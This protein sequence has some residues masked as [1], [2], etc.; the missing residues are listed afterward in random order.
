MLSVIIPAFNEENL[1]PLLLESLRTQTFQ[2][3]EVIVSDAD[4]KDKTKEIAKLWGCKIIKG[5]SPSVGRNRGAKVAKGDILVFLDSDVVLPKEFLSE[6]LRE[7]KH[8]EL[9]IA[10]CYSQPL[11]DKDIDF[12]IYGTANAYLKIAQFFLPQAPGHCIIVKKEIHEKIK[13]FDETIKINE[14]FDYINRAAEIGKFRYF[15]KIK[16]P[17]SMRRLDKDGRLTMSVKYAICAFYFA[18]F[19]GVKSDIFN[20]RFGHYQEKN[21]TFKDK[22]KEFKF[23]IKNDVKN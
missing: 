18:L 14:D 23:K 22:I 3:F 21:K 6:T 5:G 15:K 17:I 13:G 4:S 8:R 1:L 16:I 2:D 11:S 19:G 10:G 7:F 9:D 12:I 20:Y